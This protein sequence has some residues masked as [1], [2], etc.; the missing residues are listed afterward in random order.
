MRRTEQENRLEEALFNLIKNAGSMLRV[1]LFSMQH[2]QEQGG[3]NKHI[4]YAIKN[5]TN[6]VLRLVE[7]TCPNDLNNWAEAIV[8]AEEFVQMI[9]DERLHEYQNPNYFKAILAKYK[10]IKEQRQ[11]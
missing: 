6:V 1:E 2:Y 3:H 4:S 9:I 11:G 7:P 10:Y 5:D 8:R